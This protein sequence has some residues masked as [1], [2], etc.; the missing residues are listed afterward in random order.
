MNFA[1]Q[2][3][4]E[5]ADAERKFEEAKLKEA[6]E[7][8]A[9]RRKFIASLKAGRFS[10]KA[11]LEELAKSKGQP[12]GSIKLYQWEDTSPDWEYEIID[13]IKK[14]LLEE[15]FSEK[16]IQISHYSMEPVG[17]DPMFWNTVY[18]GSVVVTFGDPDVAV[19]RW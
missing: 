10:R 3:K 12:T 19:R 9:A 7:K 16:Q 18:N 14:I 5:L 2:M 13:H 15:G 17:S 8:E 4:I 6:L 1:E 11:I